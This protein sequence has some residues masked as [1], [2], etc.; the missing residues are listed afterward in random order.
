[1]KHS[2]SIAALALLVMASCK[3]DNVE[4]SPAYTPP[5]PPAAT[6]Y[7]LTIGSYWI[8]ENTNID[9]NNVETVNT[10]S[11]TDSCYVADDTVIGGR[12]YSVFVG[13][14]LSPTTVFFRRDSAGFIIDPAGKIY[15][16]S[17]DFIST[18]RT[19]SVPGYMDTYYKMV[20]PVTGITVP[21]GTFTCYDYQGMAVF[22]S[23]YPY[24]NP[25]FMHSYYGNGVGLVR[26]VAFFAGSPGYIARRLLRY[27]VQ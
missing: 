12:T 10:S 17:A 27:H 3:K 2:F 22:Q 7:Q 5:P 14:M 9:T 6:G 25:R 1:M 13:S 20:G 26:E 19:S 21:A 15:Y 8:Y 11:P 24:D 4:V 23:G 16:S 18:L